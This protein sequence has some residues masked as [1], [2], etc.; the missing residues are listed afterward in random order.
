MTVLWR[1]AIASLMALVL[2]I[3]RP[4]KGHGSRSARSPPL[5]IEPS[6]ARREKVHSKTFVAHI[7]YASTGGLTAANTHPFEQQG[8]LLAHNGVIEDLPKLEAR[9]G[10]TAASSA[11]TASERFFAL[12]TKEAEQHGGNVTAGL[13]AAARWVA[14]QLPLFA[15]NVVLI[16]SDELWALRYPDTHTLYVLQRTPGGE[17]VHSG[18]A[19]TIHVRSADVGDNGAVVIASEPMDE[20]PAWRGLCVRRASARRPRAA[21]L[22]DDRDRPRAAPPVEAR[23]S[24]PPRRGVPGR[25]LDRG[26]GQ[27]RAIASTARRFAGRRG[28]AAIPDSPGARGATA[29]A[30][31]VNDTFLELSRH[32]PHPLATK[33]R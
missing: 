7:R 21:C 31:R 26:T 32:D 28:A 16:T 10:T 27:V 17:L 5:R 23:R 19:G 15:L 18:A 1:R 8:R 25:T 30:G 29:T 22:I 4:M 11:A 33:E 2:D 12:V 6:R 13:V 14:E 24:R 3:S 9:L 20:D